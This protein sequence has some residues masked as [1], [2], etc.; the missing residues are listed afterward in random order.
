MSRVVPENSKLSALVAELASM[1]GGRR[2]SILA[3]LPTDERAAVTRLLA[4][5]AEPTKLSSADDWK[6]AVSPWLLERL[7]AEPSGSGAFRVTPAAAEG[8]RSAVEALRRSGPKAAAAP[9][10]RV[11]RGPSLVGAILGAINFKGRRA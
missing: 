9:L 6:A 5:E 1:S 4:A 2:A 3:A 11:P 10:A 8:L 7:A